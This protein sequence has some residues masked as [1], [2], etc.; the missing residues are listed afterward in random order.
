MIK[1]VHDQKEEL[2]GPH[3]RVCGSQGVWRPRIGDPRSSLVPAHTTDE[4]S[5]ELRL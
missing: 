1:I 2:S 4:R 5:C 3:Q